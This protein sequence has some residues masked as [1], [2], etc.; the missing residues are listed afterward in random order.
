V[1]ELS[2]SLACNNLTISNGE[3]VRIARPSV[4]C[5]VIVAVVI[6]VII[7]VFVV[8]AIVALSSS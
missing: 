3:A 1:C 6:T 4:K 7:V 8:V 5:M 2:T